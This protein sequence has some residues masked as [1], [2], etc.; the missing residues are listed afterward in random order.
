MPYRKDLVTFMLAVRKY[1]QIDGGIMTLHNKNSFKALRII[2]LAIP[3]FLT[4]CHSDMGPFPMPSGYAHHDKQYKAAPGPEPIFKKI[5]HMKMP[6]SIPSTH[7]DRQAPVAITQEPFTT[8]EPMSVTASDNSDWDYAANDLIRRLI[9]GFGQPTEPV[10]LQRADNASEKDMN[11]EQALHRTMTSHGI[12]ITPAPGLA[13]FTLD[14]E[15]HA[16]EI[17]DGSRI[18][19]SVALTRKGTQLAGESGIY[20][21]GDT[22][23]KIPAMVAPHEYGGSNMSSN[24]PLPLMPIN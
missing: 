24:A 7:T 5:E 12:N 21:L 15:A 6:Q 23:P 16:L 10:Y 3:F 8:T 2:L 18:M 14:Y 1:I 13:A 11:I 22:P 19:I 17:G 20:S 9:D 4:A